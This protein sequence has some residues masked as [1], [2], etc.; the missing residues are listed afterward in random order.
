MTLD[1]YSA[2]AKRKCQVLKNLDAGH[3]EICESLENL[4]PMKPSKEPDGQYD[5][6]VLSW[7]PIYTNNQVVIAHETT[8]LLVGGGYV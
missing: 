5:E 4:H 6:H 7:E 1:R 2:I 8:Y 3:K